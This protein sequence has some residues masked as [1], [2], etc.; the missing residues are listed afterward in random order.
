MHIEAEDL[1]PGFPRTTYENYWNGHDIVLAN[2][3]YG[4]ELMN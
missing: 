3:D 4:S 1:P 2:Y